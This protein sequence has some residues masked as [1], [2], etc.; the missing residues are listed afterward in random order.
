MIRNLQIVL[1]FFFTAI[2]LGKNNQENFKLAYP[3]FIP[4]G[5]SFDVS[6]IT[7]NPYTSAD[8]LDLYFLPDSK[9]SLNSV[10]LKTLNKNSKLNLVQTTFKNNSGT[11]YKTSIDLSDSSLSS[12]NY[13]QILLNAKTDYSSIS[14]LKLYGVYLKTDS[15]VGFLKTNRQDLRKPE[16][17]F[18]TANLNLFRPQK[19][20]GKALLFSQN[21]NLSLPL[22]NFYSDDLRIEFWVKLSDNSTDFFKI[23][24]SKNLSTIFGLSTNDFQSLIINSSFKEPELLNPAFLSKKSWYH[25]IIAFSEKDGDIKMYCDGNLLYKNKA[26]TI[27]DFH[28][29]EINF[30][31]QQSNKKFQVD[32]LRI[33]D[34]QNSIETNINNRNYLNFISDS[35]N[36]LQQFSFDNPD[37]FVA[38]KSRLNIISNNLQFVKSDAPI[39]ARAPEL[40]IN[41]LSSSYELKWEGGDFKQAQS[42]ILEKSTNSSE[43]KDIYS[44]ETDNT[45]EKSYTFLD[46]KDKSSDVVFYRVK[47]IN[48]DGSVVYSGAVKVGQGEMQPF[49]V[50]QNYPNPFN[51]K[52]T[53]NIDLLL[54]SEVQVQVYNMEGKEIAKVFKGRLGKGKH[55]FSFDGTELPSG[56]YLYR[57]STSDYTQ[58]KKMILTK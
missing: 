54:D 7:S 25:I 24:N 19:N 51:P 57:V 55:T 12:G 8:K 56:V 46:K 44:I 10:E 2:V 40:N 41:L 38:M 45:I 18:I 34:A 26:Q 36:V 20:A 4:I 50:E 29:I 16:G 39:F 52:T 28:D 11:A 37:D 17:R 14:P 49:E 35:S 30:G 23:L 43:Y 6:L 13:F 21:A 58:T 9:L 33:V 1:F 31:T 42:Y 3:K 22:S 5:S 53:I 27:Y 32:L 48:Y 15:V 47:Q